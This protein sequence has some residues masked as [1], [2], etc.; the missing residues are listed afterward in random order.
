MSEQDQ[1]CRQCDGRFADPLADAVSDVPATESNLEV[2]AD[3][4]N[5]TEQ[6]LV[7]TGNVSVTQGVRTMRADKVTADR[8]Q[9]TALASGNVLFREPGIALTGDTIYYDST[10]EQAEVTGAQ[11]VMHSRHMSGAAETLS[12]TNG[13]SISKTVA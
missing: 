8:E 5:V 10:L 3:N 1:R 7:F 4:T 6:E 9:Q 11:F 2:T 13:K 12:R